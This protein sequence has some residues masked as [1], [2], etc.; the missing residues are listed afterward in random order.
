METMDKGKDTNAGSRPAASL[1]E[2]QA[3]PFDPFDRLRA[4]KLRAGCLCHNVL[5]IREGCCV[6]RLSDRRLGLL[7]EVGEIID[8]TSWC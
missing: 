3:R 5:C 1:A 7:T 8:M 6:M 2:R 4:G